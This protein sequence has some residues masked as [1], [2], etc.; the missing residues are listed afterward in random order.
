MVDDAACGVVEKGLAVAGLLLICIGSAVQGLDVFG[1]NGDSGGGVIDNLGPVGH[2][3]PAGSTVGVEDSVSLAEDSLAV[4][5][6]SA[7]V[8]LAAVSLVASG[9]QLRGVVFPLLLS[10]LA[11]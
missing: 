10:Q 8:V 4:E 5:I 11:D 2:G 6:D 3:V 1:I 9:L 7:V